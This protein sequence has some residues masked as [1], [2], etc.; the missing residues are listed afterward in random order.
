M[1]AVQTTVGNTKWM[2]YDVKDVS[3]FL[4]T[5][6]RAACTMY[7]SQKRNALAKTGKEL[8]SVVFSSRQVQHTSFLPFNF[9]LVC[10]RGKTHTYIV[11]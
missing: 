9:L 8:Q 10:H 6:K 4:L 7:N 1:V 11:V 2:P 3:K 5:A